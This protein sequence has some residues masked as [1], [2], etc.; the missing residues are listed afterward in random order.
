MKAKKFKALLLKQT[1]EYAEA[2]DIAITKLRKPI[3]LDCEVKN[4]FETVND[5]LLG[6]EIE[7]SE[8]MSSIPEDPKLK[9]P[10]KTDILIALGEIEEVKD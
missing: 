5:E 6:I 2:R 10:N 3:I 9:N 4:N 8:E 1:S 7:D